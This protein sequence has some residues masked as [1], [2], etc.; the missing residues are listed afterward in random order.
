MVWLWWQIQT[1][2]RLDEILVRISARMFKISVSLPELRHF[3][4]SND[5]LI[6]HTHGI[7]EIVRE[8]LPGL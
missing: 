6:M 7:F 2:A 8:L 4:S 1:C 5:C 3:R